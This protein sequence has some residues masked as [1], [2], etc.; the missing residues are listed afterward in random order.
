MK[1]G[2]A[3]TNKQQEMERKSRSHCF[4]VSRSSSFNGNNA[5]KWADYFYVPLFASPLITDEVLKNRLV[6]HQNAENLVIKLLM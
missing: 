1:G 4:P 2:K 5:R 3:N 6:F